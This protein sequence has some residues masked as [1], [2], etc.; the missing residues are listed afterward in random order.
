MKTTGLRDKVVLTT[1]ATS[2]IGAAIA[3][4][5]AARGAISLLVGRNAEKLAEVEHSIRGKGG[6]SKA[7]VCNLQTLTALADT[8]TGATA[9]FIMDFNPRTATGIPPSVEPQKRKLCCSPR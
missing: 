6:R 8:F 5:P 4:E 3:R 2:G 1:G 7:Y 9:T